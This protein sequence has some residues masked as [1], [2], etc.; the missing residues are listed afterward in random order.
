MKNVQFSIPDAVDAPITLALAHTL[1]E[2]HRAAAE[3]PDHMRSTVA[4]N[5]LFEF[6]ADTLAAVYRLETGREGDVDTV[7]GA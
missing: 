5:G 4:L 2:I 6:A 7:P 3:A 1:T